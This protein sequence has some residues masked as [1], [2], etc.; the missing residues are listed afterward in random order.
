MPFAARHRSDPAP[1]LEPLPGLVVRREEDPDTMAALQGLMAV[2]L[3]GALAFPVAAIVGGA[4]GYG[5]SKLVAWGVPK[6]SGPT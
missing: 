1:Q 5:A 2:G 6:I 3:H 4:A